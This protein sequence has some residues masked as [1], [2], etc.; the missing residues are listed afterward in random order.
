MEPAGEVL[1]APISLDPIATS[2]EQL[3]VADV[4]RPASRSGDDVIDFEIAQLEVC[5]ATRTVACLLAVQRGSIL[6]RVVARDVADVC[7][8]GD[9][10]AMH[11]VAPQ[12]LV[13]FDA[14]HDQFG[15]FL[16]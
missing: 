6:E 7:A 9:V 3:Q 15:G 2:A 14:L 12:A 1:H 16:R 8:S 5:P 13:G 11:D 10:R 4:I